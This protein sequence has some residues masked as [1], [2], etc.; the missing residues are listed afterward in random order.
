MWQEADDDSKPFEHPRGCLYLYVCKYMSYASKE[1]IR[2]IY[3]CTV[4]PLYSKNCT[5]AIHFSKGMI[6][7]CLS[8]TIAED[9]RIS[10]S[11]FKIPADRPWPGSLDFRRGCWF[12]DWVLMAISVTTAKLFSVWNF[13]GWFVGVDLFDL[14]KLRHFWIS[15]LFVWFENVKWTEVPWMHC[16]CQWYGAFG[17]GN[18]WLRAVHWGDQLPRETGAQGGHWEISWWLVREFLENATTT[19]V[20]LQ[21]TC[22]RSVLSSLSR[23]CMRL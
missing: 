1:Y 6:L 3:T 14:F 13:L 20:K 15:S 23:K 18:M 12:G 9:F 17:R 8:P 19:L 4:F 22:C 7:R 5:L 10:F 21:G 11:Y 16:H 2:I